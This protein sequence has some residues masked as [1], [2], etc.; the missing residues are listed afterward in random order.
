MHSKE[1]SLAAWRSTPL[2]EKIKNTYSIHSTKGVQSQVLPGV[3]PFSPPC[4][5]TDVNFKSSTILL[6]TET[7]SSIADL[8]VSIMMKRQFIIQACSNFL[9]LPPTSLSRL[10]FAPR[11]QMASLFPRSASRSP[12]SDHSTWLVLSSNSYS[13]TSITFSPPLHLS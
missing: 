10:K 13:A 4:A 12:L 5:I 11:I 3:F 7:D 6:R 1:L 8:N 9:F 2:K